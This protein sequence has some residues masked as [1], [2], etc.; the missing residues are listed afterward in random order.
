[1][2]YDNLLANILRGSRHGFNSLA[3][4]AMVPEGRRYRLPLLFQQIIIVRT[5][6]VM[7]V[8]TGHITS[9]FVGIPRGDLGLV[10]AVKTE[11]TGL[12]NKEKRFSRSMRMVAD[13]AP[14][15]GSGPVDFSFL[16]I[17][18]MAELT[19]LFHGQDEVAPPL[20]MARFAQLGSV[21][22]VVSDLGCV[23]SSMILFVHPAAC[24]SRSRS[25]SGH[26]VE[27]KIQGLVP[28]LRRTPRNRGHCRNT[29]YEQ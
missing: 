15:C 3:R 14:A 17:Q 20:P 10:V 24:F 29:H 16:E 2:V 21:G 4:K 27:K 11:I 9:R 18:C 13:A 23:G 25:G 6:R 7:T 19:K 26:A 28:R 1:M 5:V 12:G 22:A 8:R